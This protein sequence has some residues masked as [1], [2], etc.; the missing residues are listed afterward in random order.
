MLLKK[1]F[2][3]SV[4]FFKLGGYRKEMPAAFFAITILREPRGYQHFLFTSNDR[5]NRCGG[6]TKIITN[7]GIDVIKRDKFIVGTNDLNRLGLLV[8]ENK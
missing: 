2:I 3:R 8:F 6:E 1:L 4:T 5:D 7:H